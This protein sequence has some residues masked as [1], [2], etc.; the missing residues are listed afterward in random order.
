MTEESFLLLPAILIGIIAA[1]GAVAFHELIVVIRTWLYGSL[2]AEYLYGRGVWLLIAWPALGGLIVGV[3]VRFF[4]G[5]GHG[6]PEVIESVIKSQGFIRPVVAIQ[7]IITASITIGT[8]GSAG[9]EGPIVQVGAAIASGVGQLF[10]IARHHMPILVGCGTAAGISSI[11]NAPIG[12]V[13]FT[14]EVILQD[15]S[16]RAFAPLMIASVVANVTTRAIF[17]GFFGEPYNAIFALP[18][19]VLSSFGTG[20]ML[21]WTQLPNFALLGIACGIIASLLTRLML[22]MEQSMS[23]SRTPR[24]LRPGIGGA[25]VG[26]LGVLFVMI[27]GWWLMGVPKPFAFTNYPMPAFFGD[28]YGVVEQLLSPGYYARANGHVLLGMLAVLCIVKIVATCLTL[29]SGGSGGVIAPSLFLG[30]TTGAALG[31]LLQK[32]HLFTG[33]YPAVY[34]L[35]GMG[36]VLGAVVHAPLA[37][38]L[39]L[40]ELTS[41]YHIILPAMLA[42]ILAVGTAR[43]IFPESVY[44]VHLRAR[45]IRTGSTR[46]LGLL[47]RISVEQIGMEPASVIAQDMPMKRVLEMMSGEIRDAAIIRSDGTYF[48]MLCRP[49]I[50]AAV[51]QPHSM[52]LLVAGELARTGVPMLSSVDDLA[53]A[54]ELFAET[55][56]GTLAVCLPEAPDRVVGVMSHQ[57]LLKRYHELLQEHR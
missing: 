40:L 36:A 53:K 48:G 15:F 50:E 24:L 31:V 14:L 25:A 7:K 21:T 44:S 29:A 41:D 52:P 54:L 30:A 33:V 28:G 57:F 13:L 8:G 20:G 32:L 18:P 43:F 6:V 2:P 49:D 16:I 17:Q 10:R 42:T 27:F 3:L 4:G 55:N 39:I 37:A 23:R 35:I 34:A 22:K 26:V 47:R 45:G 56:V 12:G 5:G 11:F 9:A 51:L 19:D 46:D 1:A 38:I